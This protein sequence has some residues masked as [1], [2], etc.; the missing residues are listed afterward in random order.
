[1]EDDPRE[2]T[3]PQPGKFFYAGWLIAIVLLMVATAGLVL[4]RER[5]L[6]RQTSELK[7]EV[8]AGPHVLVAQVGEN[9]P[10][11][12]LHLPASVRGFD[13]TQIYAKVPGY[14]RAIYVDKGDRVRAGQVI[15]TIESPET[16]KEVANY[17]ANYI[18]AKITLDRDAALLR[19]QVIARQDYDNQYTVMAQAKAMWEQYKELQ[20]Y[21][22]L[23]APYDGIVAARYVDPGHLIPAATGATSTTDAVVAIARLSPVRVFAYVP[24]NM[25]PFI[26]NGDSASVSV[27]EYPGRQFKGSVTRHPE[28]LAP[29]SRTMLVEVDLANPDAAL[30]PGMYGSVE[31]VVSVSIRTPLVPDDALIFRDNKVYVPV[32]RNNHLHLAEV[33]LG[34]DNGVEVQVT[35]GVNYDDLVALNVG[36]A[37]RDGE[38]VQPVRSSQ[39]DTTE[40]NQM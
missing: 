10:V 39:T 1:M 29:D 31:F 30:L 28:A 13:E 6:N 21:E 33:A 2:Y 22:I 15:A 35:K 4:A 40:K 36:Q 19:T 25:S 18:L 23:R 16:D 26:K 32:V 11:R 34:Y 24:Q 17:R 20:G 5:W 3:G 38:P 27:I 8:E 12:V 7:T 14:I 9:P 37:A